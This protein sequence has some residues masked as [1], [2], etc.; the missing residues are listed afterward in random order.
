[1]FDYVSQSI[2]HGDLDGWECDCPGWSFDDFDEDDCTCQQDA[3]D[4]SNY[5]EAAVSWIWVPDDDD[6]GW[7]EEAVRDVHFLVYFDV[8]DPVGLEYLVNGAESELTFTLPVE[9]KLAELTMGGSYGPGR[10][11]PAGAELTFHP[12]TAGYRTGSPADQND[13]D[14]DSVISI[15]YGSEVPY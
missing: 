9:V 12:I 2:S 13:I 14:L 10:V 1:M 15:G 3:I 6:F 11:V 5:V 4:A 7:E 8:L